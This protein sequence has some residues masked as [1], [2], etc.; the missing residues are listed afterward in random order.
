MSQVYLV[1]LVLGGLVLALG[2]VSRLSSR[3]PITDPL[4]ALILGVL[5]GPPGLGVLDP[6]EWGDQAIIMEV[7]AEITLA[8]GVM[9]VA[10]RLPGSWFWREW[11]SMAILLGMV[12]PLMWLASGLI[13]HWVFHLPFWSSMLI[14]AVL[15]PTDPVVSTSIVTSDIAKRLVPKR[16]RHGLSAESGA[17]DGLAWPLVFLPL[18]LHE[19]ALEPTLREWF[20]QVVLWEIGGALLLAV[21]VGYGGGRLLRLAEIRHTIVETSLLDFTVALTFA[22]L[23]LASL[24]G[25]N[26]VFAVFVTGVAFAA[27]ARNEQETEHEI[28]EAV[29]RFFLLPIFVLLGMMVPWQAWWD[30]GWRGVLIVVLILLLRRLPAM[31]VLA[32]HMP[33][34]GSARDVWFLGWFGPI[35][36]AALYYA[37]IARHEAGLEQAWVAASLVVCASVVVHG[38]SARPLTNWYGASAPRSEHGAG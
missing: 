29:Y 34:V 26:G 35:G 8:I 21:V 27:S 7:A 19:G 12:M 23:G 24:L 30:G 5:I 18:L 36:V 2:L 17:N 37:S 22:V 6:A 11:R 13:I 25:V 20:G 32:R 9:G 4:V 14:G 38:M 16:L 28:Q 31:L 15:T 10:L 3:G 33:I 1:L